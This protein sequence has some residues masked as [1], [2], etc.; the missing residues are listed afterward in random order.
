MKTKKNSLKILR[1][2]I[3]SC[4]L[5][6][7]FKQSSYCMSVLKGKTGNQQYLIVTESLNPHSWTS[8]QKGLANFLENG[9]WYKQI[10]CEMKFITKLLSKDYK[11]GVV[12]P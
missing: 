11:L 5:R 8:F 7:C 6:N 10:Y 12:V 1:S 4:R 2:L 9:P 3:M